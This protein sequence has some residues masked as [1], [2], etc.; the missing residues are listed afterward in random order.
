VPVV[1]LGF[2]SV[3]ATWLVLFVAAYLRTPRESPTEG[4]KK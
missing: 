4:G 3:D 1:W 2:A